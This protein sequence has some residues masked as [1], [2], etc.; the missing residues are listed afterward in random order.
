MFQAVNRG[1]FAVNGFRNADLQARLYD[2]PAQSSEEKK[3]RG[4]R[5][6]RQLRMLRAHGLIRKVK[7]SHRY[8]LTAGGRD[9][10]AAVLTTQRV[11]LEQL[12]TVN[13]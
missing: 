8:V 5:V 2:R 9:L 13:A 7:S 11:T 4:A 6:T 3:R 1:E 10:I 12:Q